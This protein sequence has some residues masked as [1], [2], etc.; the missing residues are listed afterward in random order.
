MLERG[1]GNRHSAGLACFTIT[2]AGSLKDLTHSNA[3]SVSAILLN[4]SSL[5]WSC[6]A[7]LMLGSERFLSI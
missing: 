5:P 3:A 7:V 2:H 6:T 1:I 4:E